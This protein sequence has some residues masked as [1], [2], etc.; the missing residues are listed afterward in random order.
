[1]RARRRVAVAIL[2]AAASLTTAGLAGAQAQGG[3]G[4]V[5]ASISAA[6]AARVLQTAKSTFAKPARSGKR[7]LTPLVLR[8]VQ[9]IPSMSREQRREANRLLARPTDN[10]DPQ[11]T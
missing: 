4:D 7:E 6:R 9:A 10:P 8:L 5:R 1:M 3:R 11:Q 2:L